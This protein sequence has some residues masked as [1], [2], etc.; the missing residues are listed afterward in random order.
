MLSFRPR[1]CLERD[2]LWEGGLVRAL[3]RW[4][5]WGK[6][7]WTLAYLRPVFGVLGHA[8]QGKRCRHTRRMVLDGDQISS[9]AEGRLVGDWLRLIRK[10]QTA[11]YLKPLWSAIGHY[12][13]GF[14]VARPTTLSQGV[15][16]E[17]LSEGAAASLTGGLD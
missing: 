11:M 3:R 14:K 17:S 12:L 8:L 4:A 6:A 9:T 2:V 16:A 13:K 7:L 10:F 5:R 1:Y 15:A